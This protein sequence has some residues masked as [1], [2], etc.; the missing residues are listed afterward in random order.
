MRLL[1]SVDNTSNQ[2]VLRRPHEPE[3]GPPD[4]LTADSTLEQ[5]TDQSVRKNDRSRGVWLEWSVSSFAQLDSS[6]GQSGVDRCC[7][8][9][10]R[11]ATSRLLGLFDRGR[12][13][14]MKV[15]VD[16]SGVRWA[17]WGRYSSRN[18]RATS[19]WREDTSVFSNRLLMWSWMV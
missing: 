12:R 4:G 8:Y 7:G 3:D 11:A 10:K 13:C 17:S 18:T 9:S 19:S 16:V 15:P 2:R 14:W 6:T 1:N 5:A